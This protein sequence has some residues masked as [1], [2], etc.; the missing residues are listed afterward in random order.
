MKTA[1]L[2]AA[3]IAVLLS[4]ATRADAGWTQFRGNPSNNAVIR[5]TLSVQWEVVTDGRISAS[6]TFNAGTVFLGTNAG[7]L[8]AIRAA[9][10]QVRWKQH[11]ARA[12]MSA[13]LLYDGLVVVGEGNAATPGALI[14]YD[15]QSGKLRWRTPLPGTGMPTPALVDGVLVHQDDSGRVTGM[16]PVT[17]RILYQRDVHSLAFMSAALPADQSTF[18]TSGVRFNAVLKVDA[19]S[20]RVLWRSNPFP[21]S[22]SGIGDC[23]LASDG[24]RIFG[25]YVVPE[26][27]A[28]QADVGAAAREHAY[29]LDVRNGALLWDAPLQT[30]ILPIRNQA[31]IPVVSGGVVY[32]GSAVSPWVSA[33]DARAG[34]VLWRTQTYG[35]VKGAIAV[36]Q[37]VLYFGDVSG[38]L[39]ALDARTGHKLGV[40]SMPTSFNVGSPIIIGKTLVIGSFTGSVYAVPLSIIRNSTR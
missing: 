40:M 7:T 10:G 29:A 11:V 5:G 13:P 2:T 1:I 3:C 37:G 15:Q 38:Y 8:Y 28:S 20:G 36:R 34:R 26:S 35:A 12:L 18:V 30:G 21:K 33:I 4:C 25:D 32:I 17:G 27:A 14:A 31:A 16:D 24:S 6:P 22:A 9:S 39:W 19:Q 23:P